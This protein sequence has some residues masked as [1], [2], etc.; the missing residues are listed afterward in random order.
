MR[1]LLI[2]GILILAAP[3][4]LSGFSEFFSAYAC[5]DCTEG[6]DNEP[7]NSWIKKHNEARK[8]VGVP[9]IHWDQDLATIAKKHAD[10]LARDCA[11]I[12]HSGNGFGENIAYTWG[13]NP[14]YSAV[15][16]WVAEKQWFD[17]EF[18]HCQKNKTCGHYTQVVWQS[19]VLDFLGCATSK[20]D[21]GKKVY[22]VC[23]YDPPG[24]TG[25]KPY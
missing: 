22:T 19:D 11:G 6:A 23:N 24:N 1:Y 7:E 15:D 21:A 18:N 17:I 20:C 5:G 12:W 3:L 2:L 16:A 8:A 10:K 13:H 14:N 4:A 25:R 9:A